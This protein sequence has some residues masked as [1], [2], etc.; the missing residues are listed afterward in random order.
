VSDRALRVTDEGAQSKQLS[1]GTASLR[2]GL[3]A[4]K[5]LFTYNDGASTQYRH[6]YLDLLRKQAMQQAHIALQ[7]HSQAVEAVLCETRTRVPYIV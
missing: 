6:E 7:R 2:A 1:A 4:Y 5:I 3:D